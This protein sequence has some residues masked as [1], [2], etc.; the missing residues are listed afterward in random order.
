MRLLLIDNDVDNYDF[1][2][3]GFDR[4]IYSPSRSSKVKGWLVG[5][6]QAF[7]ETTKHDI[8]VCWFDFQAILV[9]CFTRLF[10]SPRH[11]VCI[12]VMLKDKTTTRNRLVS[13]LYAHA[14]ND[15]YFA[16]TV[17]SQAYGD[18]LNQKLNRRYKFFLLHDVYHTY[19]EIGLAIATEPYIFCGGRNGRDWK[20]M[21][22]IAKRMPDVQ[23]KFVL[24][25][26]EEEKVHLQG[27]TNVTILSDTSP[28]EFLRVLSLSSAVCIPLDTIAPA[29]L[30]VLYQAAANLRPVL[31]SE[32]VV[33][34]EYITP[35]RGY[36][37]TSNP[38]QWCSVLRHILSS[39][40]E[41]QQKASNL[42]SFLRTNCS[43]EAFCLTIRQIMNH[44]YENTSVQ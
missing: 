19:Y 39:S 32:N 43:E 40:K 28:D 23:F 6:F 37:L 10:L 4:V 17:T 9:Y 30:I 31:M 29:G 21:Y 18:W 12:N 33:T 8:I 44:S 14:L 3:T 41:S 35:D 25:T 11:I 15:K 13:R 42:R 16:A 20:L 26:D 1:L 24:P 27:L 5:A 22:Q 7:R 2:T 34:R 36:L 38:E